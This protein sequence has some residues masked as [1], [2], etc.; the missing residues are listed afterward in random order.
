MQELEGKPVAPGALGLA[1]A[2]MIDTTP[3]ISFDDT[4]ERA[5]DELL[6]CADLGRVVLADLSDPG[7]VGPEVLANEAARHMSPE[8]SPARSEESQPLGG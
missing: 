8:L 4:A 1:S 5:L 3:R 2:E 7:F 6:V